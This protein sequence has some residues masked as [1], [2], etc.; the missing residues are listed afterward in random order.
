MEGALAL[1]VKGSRLVLNFAT[2]ELGWL[3]VIDPQRTSESPIC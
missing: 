2:Q 3:E 1:G